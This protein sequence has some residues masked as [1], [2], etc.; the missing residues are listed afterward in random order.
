MSKAN[1][2]NHILSSSPFAVTYKMKDDIV[3]LYGKAKNYDDVLEVCKK[4]AKSKLFKHV[5]NK[6]EVEGYHREPV[7]APTIQS[8]ELEGKKVD[9]LVIGGGVIGSAILRELSKYNISTLL[10]DKEEDLAMHASS[11]NDGCIHVGIDLK[12]NS[13]KLKYLKRSKEL[14]PQLCEDLDIEYRKDGQSVAFTDRV[15]LFAARIYLKIKAKQNGLK[16]I[17][18]YSRKKF[19]KVE[20]NIS[21]E[22][23]GG[24]YFEDA[25]A[26]CPYNFTI[27]LAESAVINGAE[28]SFNT[29]VTDM[30]VADGVIQSVK[31]NKGTIYPKVVINAAGVFADDIARMAQD[32][33]FSIHPR[34]G[35]D[36]IMDKNVFDKLSKTGMTVKG[37]ANKDKKAHSK[38][39][40][41]IP[42]ID[43][44]SL[45]GPNAIEI[46]E[47]EDFTTTKESVDAIMAKHH[48]T[49]EALENKDII[50]YFSGVR[51]P[52]FEEDF[53][54][55]KGKWTKNIVNAAGIQS[56]GLTAA[57]AI[58]EEIASIT[59]GILG[60][61]EKKEHWDPKRKGLKAL[62][63]LPLEERDRLIKTNPLYGKII[64]RCEEIS[65]GEIVDCIHSVIPPTT[66]DGVK[67]RVRAGM[68]RC[69]GGFCQPLVLNIMAREQERDVLDISKKGEGKILF[70]D[71]KE[72]LNHE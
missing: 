41:I 72:T 61:I 36:I 66:V 12:K 5:V 52:T 3:F 16:G 40:G 43:K 51:A 37:K 4:V 15:I 39:G 54:V 31:T 67:R 62:R 56:P 70:G 7:K 10:V 50:T 35:T 22:I 27:A 21:K 1:K 28:V 68:G 47:K 19:L 60:N 13:N 65:E 34:K 24:A 25:G 26:I 6:I 48:K 29:I 46:Q 64:C 44:N 45:V 59:V 2:L 53:I 9:V 33:Y 8:N 49:I 20:P 55:E 17:H 32:E 69:Q 23:V 63:N 30:E 42:T 18:V 58:A 11:R 14:L 38:G 71:I 57:P